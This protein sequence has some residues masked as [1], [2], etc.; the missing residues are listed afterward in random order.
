MFCYVFVMSG[1]KSLNFKL[2]FRAFYSLKALKVY[3]YLLK[4]KT[5]TC[6]SCLC[7][8]I[9]FKFSKVLNTIPA[10]FS[11]SEELLFYTLP[12]KNVLLLNQTDAHVCC[13][14]RCTLGPATSPFS[15]NISC[16][17]REGPNFHQSHISRLYL[18]PECLCSAS[19]RHWDKMGVQN[20]SNTTGS[21]INN[22]VLQVKSSTLGRFK[23]S[24][25]EDFCWR[26]SPANKRGDSWILQI[27]TRTRSFPHKRGILKTQVLMVTWTSSAT[28]CH[29]CCPH[30]FPPCITF[31][32]PRILAIKTYK[33]NSMLYQ[34]NSQALVSVSMKGGFSC[35]AKAA[36]A[37]MGADLRSQS[38]NWV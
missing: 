23:L 21:G 17:W 1:A 18:L 33:N 2:G 22:S 28:L 38:L 12:Q 19:Q 14:S 35:C 9:Y 37:T 27:A 25:F 32:L 5:Y 34:L 24:D 8:I 7:G 3:S 4:T 16:L 11:L 31:F 15:S 26:Q 10:F 36:W 6:T 29:I 13:C 20:Q 30:N